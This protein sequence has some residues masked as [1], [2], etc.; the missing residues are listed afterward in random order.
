VGPL[1]LPE[2]IKPEDQASALRKETRRVG[3]QLLQEGRVAA[4]VFAGGRGSRRGYDHPKEMFK[5]GPVSD[6][7]LYQILAEQVSA[8]S[9]RPGRAIPT[10]S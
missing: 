6:R 7:S 3:N 4:L 2:V 1:E 9:R 8:R 5:I 10:T